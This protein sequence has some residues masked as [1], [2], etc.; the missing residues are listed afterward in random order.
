MRAHGIHA[1][2]YIWAV[3]TSCL[4]CMQEFFTKKRLAAHFQHGGVRC[5]EQ[6]KP[7]YQDPTLLSQ[8]QQLEGVD[9]IPFTPTAGP[10]EQWCT[11]TVDEHRGWTHR[12]RRARRGP[13]MARK[14]GPP[15][16]TA[17]R[18]FPTQ[19]KVDQISTPQH[20]PMPMPVQFI[21]HF[22]SGRGRNGD[23]QHHLEFQAQQGQR[24]IKVLSLDVAIDGHLGNLASDEAFSF[25]ND[26]SRRGYILSFMVGPPCQTF[27]KS[28]SEVMVHHRSVPVSLDGAFQAST[29][30]ST[31]KLN[32]ATFCGVFLFR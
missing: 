12:P 28:D 3:R 26:K 31:N 7:R 8:D 19:L 29:A 10:V 21:L 16:S 14:V 30:G 20:I 5:L 22:F 2:H 4:C 18:H 27:T 25:W 32:A 11:A 6:L 24:I 1:E 9:H 15:S 17:R 23:L 13:L